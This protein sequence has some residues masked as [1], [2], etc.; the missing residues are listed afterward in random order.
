MP[1]QIRAGLTAEKWI[2]EWLNSI[3][4][5]EFQKDDSGIYYA[6]SVNPVNNAIALVREK[7]GK[8]MAMECA[9]ISDG[10]DAMTAQA[11]MQ[12]AGVTDA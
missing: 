6:L 4:Q 11:L 5:S 9:I 3:P 10:F 7:F 8:R 12:R 1:I 2:T